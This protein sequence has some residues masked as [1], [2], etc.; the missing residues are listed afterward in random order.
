MT[1][2]QLKLCHSVTSLAQTIGYIKMAQIRHPDYCTLDQLTL[3]LA[4]R[5]ATVA[6]G[7]VIYNH[8]E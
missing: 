6:Y 1:Q 7:R 4:E 8:V 3:K 5:K 2:C